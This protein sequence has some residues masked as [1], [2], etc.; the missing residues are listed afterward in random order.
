MKNAWRNPMS[1]EAVLNSPMR[2]SFRA[3]IEKMILEL[4]PEAK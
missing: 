1:R 2:L 4:E 3:E